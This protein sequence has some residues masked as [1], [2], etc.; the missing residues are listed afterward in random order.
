M[1]FNVLIFVLK[2]EGICST[3][4]IA[5]FTENTVVNTEQRPGLPSVLHSLHVQYYTF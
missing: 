4:H 3:L 1:V 2:L 5:M